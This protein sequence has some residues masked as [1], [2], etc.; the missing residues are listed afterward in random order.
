MK[1]ESVNK[2]VKASN[3]PAMYYTSQDKNEHLVSSR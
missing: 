2:R 3:R 1:V